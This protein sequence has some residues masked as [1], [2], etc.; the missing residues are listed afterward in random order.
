MQKII[1]NTNTLF[2]NPDPIT[3]NHQYDNKLTNTFPISL[4]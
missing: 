1:S 4:S 3:I 2:K